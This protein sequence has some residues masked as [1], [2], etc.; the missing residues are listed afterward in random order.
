MRHNLS[1]CCLF[2]PRIYIVVLRTHPV[3]GESHNQRNATGEV[4]TLPWLKIPTYSDSVKHWDFCKGHW[5]HFC[6][7][8][9]ECVGRL[10]HPDTTNIKRAYQELCESLFAT[11]QSIPCG[12]HNNHMP[13]WVKRLRDLLML[14]SLHPNVDWWHFIPAFASWR[15]EAGAMGR[16][17]QFHWQKSILYSTRK[18]IL[19]L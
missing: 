14:F 18:A 3:R 17:C 15:E 8:T 16:S 9:R 7:F 11:E 6:F 12:H 19:I 10:P 5:K 4:A 13:W 2:A 1:Y